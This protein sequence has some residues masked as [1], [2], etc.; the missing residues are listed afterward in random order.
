VGA[1][2]QEEGWMKRKAIAWTGGIVM[3]L[4]FSLL[5]V[6]AGCQYLPFGVT[7]VKD[8]LNNPSAYDGRQVKIRGTVSGITK[9]PLVDLKLYI[10][11][12]G[13]S[14]ITV[15]T[16]GM[17]PSANSKVIVV[18][19]VENM[20]IFNSESVGLHIREIRRIDNPLF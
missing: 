10:L 13:G 7:S 20:A 14:K 19:R 9:I 4:I 5:L 11:D 16:S 18:G 17:T 3:F 8:I 1:T 12:D 15:V 2:D 6:S